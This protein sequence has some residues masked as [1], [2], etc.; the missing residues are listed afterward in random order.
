MLLGVP[1]ASRGDPRDGDPFEIETVRV[2]GR[3]LELFA[4]PDAGPASHVVAVAIGG[5]VPD[6]QRSIA[7]FPTGPGTLGAPGLFRVGPEVV[8]FDV[9]DLVPGGDVE[10]ALLSAHELAITRVGAPAPLV[11]RRF[12]PPLPLPGRTRGVSRLAFLQPWEGN[13]A[14]SA[15]VPALDGLR[16]V[17]L[18]DRPVSALPVPLETRYDVMDAS[19]GVRAGALDAYIA[20]PQV[21]LAD[22]DGDGRDDLF[23]L[24]RYD[25]AVFRAGPDGLPTRP[26]R[27]VPLRPFTPKEE[28]RHLATSLSLYAQDLDGD[29]LADLVLHRTIGTLL[30][31]RSETLIYRNR[32]NGADPSG[33]PDLTLADEGGF[34]AIF[35][36]DVDGDGRS[37]LLQTLVP[38]GV[39]QVMRV[40]VTERAQAKF[41]LL[42]FEGEGVS[43]TKSSWEE[44]VSVP[45]DFSN[46]RVAGVIPTLA[47][48]LNGDG[49]R[50]LVWGESLEE[51]SVRLGER[52]EHGPRF[53]PR[54]ARQRVPGGER[55]LVT[56]LDGDGLDDLVLHDTTDADGKLHVL[57]NRGELPGSPSSLEPAEDEAD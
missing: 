42:R 3:P 22:D 17:P 39:I 2:P 45:L 43:T 49:L 32:G 10:L 41:R 21:A 50:D 28:L 26:T 38:F 36:Q 56:D 12:D 33:E 1:G 44:D 29:G 23:A 16:H 40:L 18:D 14:L 7:L 27:H 30:S 57:H 9:A 20:W 19:V 25:V 31:S 54:V 35:L 5:A 13:G 24:T 8:G 53:G 11:R 34:G 46:G 6:E 4:V 15:L 37:E 48:D 52:G 55:A 47:G 51:L